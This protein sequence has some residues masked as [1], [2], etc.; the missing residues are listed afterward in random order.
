MSAD[1]ID[2]DKIPK[3]TFVIYHGHH[4]D[5]AVKRA[6]LIIPMSCFTEKDGIYVN[7]EGRPQ[8]SSQVKLPIDGVNHSWTFLNKL[9]KLFKLSC[10]S[11]A[12]DLR[13]KM[14]LDHEHLGSINEIKLS[15]ISKKKPSKFKFSNQEMKSNIPNFYMTDAVSRNSKIMSEC[16]MAFLK[17]TK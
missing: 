6:D 16:S 3:K 8:I 2:F 9:S 4:G 12:N 1:E 11:D 13:E 10:F 5:K 15:K 14:F 7:L 17:E